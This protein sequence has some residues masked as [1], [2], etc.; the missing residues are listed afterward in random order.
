MPL[1][2]AV[3]SLAFSMWPVT[4]Q[5]FITYSLDEEL[6][7][8][9]LTERQALP[10]LEVASCLI[11]C[12]IRKSTLLVNFR[13]TAV[14]SHSGSYLNVIILLTNLNSSFSN[15]KPHSFHTH[16]GH[17]Q[18]DIHCHTYNVFSITYY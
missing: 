16:F 17:G 7:V 1:F 18:R 2:S 13:V 4:T 9:N 10:K 11:C 8:V 15:T 5:A 3:E 6:V 14:F 12:A